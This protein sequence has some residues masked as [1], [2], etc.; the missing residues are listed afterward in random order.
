MNINKFFERLTLKILK[1]TDNVAGDKVRAFYAKKR[2]IIIGK[3]TYGYEHSDIAKGTVIGSF[4]SIA[5]GTKIGLM[6]HPLQFVSTHPF[7]YYKS[8]KFIDDD[9]ID[10]WNTPPILED[11]VWVGSNVVILPGVTIHKGSV[12]AAGAVVNKDVPPYAIVGGVP[13]KVIK[14]R[15]D[16]DLRKQ[17]ININWSSWDDAMI[18]M[19]I[20]LF[21]NPK[22]FVE[23]FKGDGEHE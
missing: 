16:E 21:Y 4:C 7:L 2:D 6:N 8:R 18:R 15:F 14:Y 3:Y 20:E 12:I 9:M 5:S 10:N 11:D 23:K 17:L 1:K 19:N 22:S 13:A